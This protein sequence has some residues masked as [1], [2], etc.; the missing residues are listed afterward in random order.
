MNKK[1]TT[2]EL[3]LMFNTTRQT[4]LKKAKE[5][6]LTP[7]Y[8]DNNKKKG[9]FFY[10]NEKRKIE[11]LVNKRHNKRIEVND[12]IQRNVR[13]N[14]DSVMHTNSTVNFENSENNG[15]AINNAILELL[16]QIGVKLDTLN[17]NLDNIY[18]LLEDIHYSDLDSI[19]TNLSNI[20]SNTDN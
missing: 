9:R 15:V 8:V 4:I 19:Q 13:G 11:K 6:E 20:E 10:E 12:F 7:R 1:Y 16:L 3:A 14:L 18:S 17:H 5:L 2:R